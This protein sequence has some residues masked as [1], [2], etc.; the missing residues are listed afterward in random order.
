M[1]L[2]SLLTGPKLKDEI[3]K[4]RRWYHSRAEAGDISKGTV[5]AM[6]LSYRKLEP[7][8]GALAPSEISK[9]KW[10]QYQD[11]FYENYPGQDCSNMKKFF[12]VLVSHCLERGLLERRP[13][14]KDR[15]AKR[16]RENRKRK[17]ARVFTDAEILQL[18]KSCST[19]KERLGVRLA[20]MMGFRISD[21]VNLSWD[22]INLDAEI[23]YISFTEGDDKADFQGKCPIPDPIVA[24]LRT[25]PQEHP[26]WLFPKIRKPSEHWKTQSFDALW[27]QVKRRA[28]VDHGTFH[29]LRHYRLT[30]D[31]KDP[32][33]T[34]AQVCLVRRVSLK[35]A[36]DHYIH[37]ELSDLAKLRNAGVL[38]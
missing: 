14:I 5:T 36:S 8:W 25:M 23:P 22:R 27:R 32:R 17:K 4:V 21:V 24:L 29:G 11:W 38:Q 16:Q 12:S 18:D 20:Y 37:P 30:R 26:R 34:A 15:N 9:E 7:F 28:G 2:T 3:A 13:T 31:F 19:D 35:T 33:F 6:D 10:D 1:N